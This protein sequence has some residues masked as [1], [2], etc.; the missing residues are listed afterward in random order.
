MYA[1]GAISI[2]EFIA[3]A[4]KDS[5]SNEDDEAYDSFTYSLNKAAMMTLSN[6]PTNM[7]KQATLRGT[8]GSLVPNGAWLDGDVNDSNDYDSDTDDTSANNALVH[9]MKVSSYVHIHMSKTDN[10]VQ[11]SDIWCRAQC[12]SA[13]TGHCNV[14]CMQNLCSILVCVCF[15]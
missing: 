5:W 15:S 6:S 9:G 8:R 13:S 14:K 10:F 1:T 11:Y 4:E 12:C 3:F 2:K 7:N